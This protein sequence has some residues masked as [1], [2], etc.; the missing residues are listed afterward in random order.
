MQKIAV[1]FSLLVL[2]ATSAFAQSPT[3]TIVTET[4]G[5]PSELWYGPPP[6]GVKVKPV[7]LRPGTNVVITIDDSDFFV[8][9]H[10]IDFLTRFPEQVGF[11]SWMNYLNTCAAND[12]VCLHEARIT[13]SAAFFGSQE[14]Q[15]KGFYVFRFY[16]DAFTRLPN[17][18]EMVADMRAVTGQ[19][20]ADVFQRKAAF[21]NA[22]VQ[23]P[24]FTTAYGGLTN[25]QY[26]AT[27]MSH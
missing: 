19:T 26:V 11:N 18:P 10:Y 22:F 23:R 9:Q 13:T 15:L 14:F 20:Q 1:V 4:P 7:R 3:L 25:D 5:L 17:Y 21:A 8:Q 12:A 2:L 6:N 27:L 16:K 24:E